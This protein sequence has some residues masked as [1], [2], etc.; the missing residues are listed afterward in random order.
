MRYKKTILVLVSLLPNNKSIEKES[1]KLWA[2]SRTPSPSEFSFM[3]Y[4]GP[5][6]SMKTNLK[7]RNRKIRCFLTQSM[8]WQERHKRQS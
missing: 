3:Y 2:N 1:C 7:A 5:L 6:L 4:G 8:S